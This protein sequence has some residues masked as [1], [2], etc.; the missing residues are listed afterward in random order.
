LIYSD[1]FLILQNG[2]ILWSDR[3]EIDRHE[4][5]RRQYG[6]DRHLRFALLVAQPKVADNQ[7]IGIV[8]VTRSS[9]GYNCI[10]IVAII[11][12][13]AFY[14]RPGILDVIKITPKIAVFCYRGIVWLKEK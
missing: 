2:L 1:N 10:L 5:W 11:I 9:V 4:Q 3:P 14:A 13:N 8:P 6:P 7:H 12:D